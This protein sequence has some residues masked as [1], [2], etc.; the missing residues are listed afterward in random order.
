MVRFVFNM[1]I[2][3]RGREISKR[4]GVVVRGNDSG[5]ER[6]EGVRKSTGVKWVEWGYWY[7]EKGEEVEGV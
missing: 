5:G 2:L 7:A 3:G 4:W 1:V 6:R